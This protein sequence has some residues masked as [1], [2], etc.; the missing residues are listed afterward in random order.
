MQ[1]NYSDAN[2]LYFP[3]TAKDLTSF[4]NKPFLHI[5]SVPSDLLLGSRNIS[6]RFFYYLCTVNECINKENGKKNEKS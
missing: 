3:E 4:C 2:I 5:F 1:I 6:F